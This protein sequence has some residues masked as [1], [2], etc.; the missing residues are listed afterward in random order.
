MNNLIFNSYKES[1][2]YNTIIKNTTFFNKTTKS[3][4]IEDG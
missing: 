2:F 3:L 4:K 1:N